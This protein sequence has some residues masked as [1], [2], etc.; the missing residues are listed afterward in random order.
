MPADVVDAIKAEIRRDSAVELIY[1]CRVSAEEGDKARLRTRCAAAAEE[2]D[3]GEDIVDLLDIQPEL[4]QPEA[5]A[6]ADGDRLGGLKMRISHRRDCLCVLR[7]CGKRGKNRIDAVPDAQ[8][9]IPK[10]DQI[11]VIGDITACRTQMDDTRGF[12]ANQSV[13]VDMR[14]DIV[15]NLGFA[16]G[17][18]VIVNVS[19]MRGKLFHLLRRH[20]QPERM[21][22]AGE[23]HPELPPGGIAHIR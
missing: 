20:G 3:G 15:P 16:P 4:L 21:L 22:R 11:R 5:G 1:L 17:D 13:G 6:P 8:E 2:T 10:D 12:R 23:A 19:G 18:G 14:H 9:R 7:K